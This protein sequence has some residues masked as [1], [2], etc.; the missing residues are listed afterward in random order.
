MQPRD[1]SG[2]AYLTLYGHSN[3]RPAPKGTQAGLE[4]WLPHVLRPAITHPIQAQLFFTTTELT[5]MEA[6]E[7]AFSVVSF[8]L[9]PCTL[10]TL[11]GLDTH[12]E[13]P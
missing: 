1:A 7:R 4:W 8:N 11:Y 13:C 5:Q 3:F 10:I 9:L 6:Q 2:L 12:F